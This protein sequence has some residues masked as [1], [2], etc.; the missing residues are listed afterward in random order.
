M[1]DWVTVCELTDIAPD[2][3]VCAAL[4]NE[5]VALFRFGDGEQVFAVS[6]FDPFGKANVLS[7][8]IIGSIGEQLVVASPLYKQ[9]FDLQTGACLED[10]SVSLK[11]FSV[12]V[13]NN[14]VLLAA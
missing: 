2:T 12:K 3:G 9:H 5:Q 1:S 6:N 10:D 4:N 14:Q 11:T 13:E 7:R 8:G